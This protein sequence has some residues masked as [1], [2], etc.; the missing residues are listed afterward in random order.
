MLQS[1]LSQHKALCQINKALEKQYNYGPQL[2]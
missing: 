2:N 1:I